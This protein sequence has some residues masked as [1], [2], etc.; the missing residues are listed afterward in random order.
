MIAFYYAWYDMVDWASGKISGGDLPSPTYDGGAEATL[1]RHLQQ[2]SDAGINTLACS[3]KGPDDKKT[4]DRC[5]RL[6][7]LAATSNV[8]V[9]LFMDNVDG[10]FTHK[11]ETTV[12]ALN[13]LST[14]FMSKPGYFKLDG[15]PVMLVWQTDGDQFSVADWQDI[16]Q[17]VD[18]D[19][20][21]FWMDGTTL[22]DQLN[23]FDALF[24][25]DITRGNTPTQY[26]AS[27][28]NRLKKYPDK[29][30]IAT[31]QPGYDDSLIRGPEHKIVPHT[32]DGAYYQ[33]TW[34]FAINRQACAVVLTSFNEFYEG[35][36]IEPSEKFGDKYLRW[37]KQFTEQYKGV[38]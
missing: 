12:Q 24:Y 25:F 9:A 10:W 22:F 29:P 38:P 1:T 15:R 34:E 11:K 17:Q 23:V 26:M 21:Q 13:T 6:L 20:K 30:F 16:R 4:T 28:L 8:K 7:D 2:A 27:Y 14:D 19:S 31:V 32:D 36:Y 37:T 3:W 5:M 35:S 18:P 33:A